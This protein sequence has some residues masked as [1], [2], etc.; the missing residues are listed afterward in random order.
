MIKLTKKIDVSWH[1]INK[2]MRSST[3]PIN[4]L[5]FL[6]IVLLFVFTNCG[7]SKL[8]YSIETNI[9]PNNI[10]PLTALLNIKS[11]IPCK[12]KLKY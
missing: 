6:L 2:K 5:F 9:N 1:K 4:K 10:A 3:L 7:N 11:D 12:Q 8:D